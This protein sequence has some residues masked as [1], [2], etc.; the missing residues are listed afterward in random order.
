MLLTIAE[1]AAQ[2]QV[3]V[4]HLERA[5]AAGMPSIPVGVRARRYDAAA[6]LAWLAE[7]SGEL[8]KCQSTRRPQGAT[9]FLSASAVNAYTDACRLAQV[10][11]TPS[12]SK[13]S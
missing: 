7:H 1:L 4:R 9:K 5:S 11:V 6:C 3:S 12:T 8:S 13:P 2:L 10:R